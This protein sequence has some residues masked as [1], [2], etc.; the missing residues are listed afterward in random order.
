MRPIPSWLS[1]LTLV[2]GLGF[3]ANGLF[4]LAAPFDWYLAVPGVS[5][6]GPP[7]RHFIGDIGGAYLATGLGLLAGLRWPWL[8]P[9]T[10]LAAA[11]FHGF[12]ALVH[13]LDGLA[14][15]CTPVQLQLDPFAVGVPAVLL[16]ILA[17]AA[18]RGRA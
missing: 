15:R 3:V 4:M 6:T 5:D 8:L 11:L 7:N 10:A 1:V 13:V 16:V 9:G 18:V 17:V 2:L 14:G 12:H